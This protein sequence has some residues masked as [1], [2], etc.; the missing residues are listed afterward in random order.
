[1]GECVCVGNRGGSVARACAPRRP[2]SGMHTSPPP[3]PPPYLAALRVGRLLDLPRALLGE[4]DAEEAQEVAVGRLD[5]HGRLDQRLPL[6]HQRAQLVGGEVH[7]VELRRAGRQGSAV[8]RCGQRDESES[9]VVGVC[10]YF[11]CAGFAG[12]HEWAH[13]PPPRRKTQ[14]AGA[15]PLQAP[16]PAGVHP[17]APRRPPARPPT[18]LR[19]AVA[20]LHILHLELDVAEGIRLVLRQGIGWGWVGGG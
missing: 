16:H 13:T 2:A 14:R 10:E 1:M 7:A 12:R 11:A 17:P 5:V 8:A 3:P 19:E 4:G 18:H 20:A 9:V 15:R 6:A